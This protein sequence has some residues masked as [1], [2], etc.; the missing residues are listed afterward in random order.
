MEVAH[1]SALVLRPYVQAT[2]TPAALV[3]GGGL[4]GMT[5]AMEIASSGFPVTLVERAPKLGGAAA[6][7][8]PQLVEDLIRAVEAHPGIVVERSSVITAVDGSVGAYSVVLAYDGSCF[9]EQNW[10]GVGNEAANT[11]DSHGPFGVIIVATGEPDEESCKLAILLRLTQDADGF[12]PELRVRLRPLDYV[13][14]GIFVCGSAHYPCSAAEAQFQ[15]FSAASRALRHFQRGTVTAHGTLAEVTSKTC[16]GCGDCFKV[17]PFG[18]VAMADRPGGLSLA[19]IDPL[20]CTG[21]GN[22]V[23]VCP[24]GAVT[25]SGWTDVQLEAQ[26]CFAL[27]GIAWRQKVGGQAPTLTPAQRGGADLR[28]L[29]FACKWSGYAAA[30]LAGAQK[31]SYPPS[32]RMIRLDCSGRLQPG[33]I[34]KAFELGA[35]GVLVLGCPPRVCHYE[36]GNERA[37]AVYEQ[38]EALISLLGIP[39]TRLKLAWIPPDDGPAFAA[40]VNEFVQGVENEFE[41]RA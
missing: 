6:S 19:E 10:E 7:R 16:N 18:A 23:S 11:S 14:R 39:E 40:L 34:L 30:E 13:E 37:A 1:H 25:V 26:M 22:C 35:A 27:K 29:I 12:L 2:V 36:R 17:C 5:A 32:V 15:A 3:I 8:D 41:V 24:V 28:I 21:C 20:L 9:T 31:L 38:V 33:L 4:A